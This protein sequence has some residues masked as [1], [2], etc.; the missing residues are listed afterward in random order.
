MAPAQLDVIR[1][2]SEAAGRNEPSR[3]GGQVRRE[4]S[5][6]SRLAGGA[7]RDGEETLVQSLR[8]RGSAQRGTA[9]RVMESEPLPVRPAVDGYVRCSPVQPV[10]GP[11]DYRRRLVLRGAGICALLLA[12]CAGIYFLSQLGLLGW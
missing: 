11:A 1:R 6:I 2:Q 5:L 10:Y 4:A 3:A 8:G 9:Q 7:V 12:A